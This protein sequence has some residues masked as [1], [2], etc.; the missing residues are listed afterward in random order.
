MFPFE[1]TTQF[2]TD[3]CGM[4]LKKPLHSCPEPCVTINSIF[5][6]TAAHRYQMQDCIKQHF[7]DKIDSVLAFIDRRID[8]LE[9]K[10]FQL[11]DMLF[12]VIFS[13]NHAVVRGART[14]FEVTLTGVMS[15]ALVLKKYTLLHR[16]AA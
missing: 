9:V 16:F 14:N 15:T 13:A 12:Y 3:D 11:N 1:T 8:I 6:F 10:L 4:M 7:L 2:N 5:N